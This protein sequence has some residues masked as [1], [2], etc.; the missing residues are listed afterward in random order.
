MI[1]AVVVG[2]FGFAT[3]GAKADPP[4]WGIQVGFGSGGLQIGAVV[5]TDHVRFAAN[6]GS[7]LR[8]VRPVREVRHVRPVPYGRNFQPVLHGGY[9][10]NH[11]GPNRPVHVHARTP[12][13]KKVWVPPVYRQVL[14]GYTVTHRPIYRK[15]LVENGHYNTVVAGYRC[16]I[17]GSNL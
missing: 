16:S 4:S 6:T 8:T 2:G 12:I 1:L 5:Q 9:V 10:T 15:V 13:L 14:V 7:L 3:P 11:R 17:C